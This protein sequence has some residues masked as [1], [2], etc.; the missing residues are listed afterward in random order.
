[1]IRKINKPIGEDKC[2]KE[3]KSDGAYLVIFYLLKFH[4]IFHS[5]LFIHDSPSDGKIWRTEGHV[6]M[7]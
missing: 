5:W 1:M 4:F 7:H 6:K 3:V 2:G